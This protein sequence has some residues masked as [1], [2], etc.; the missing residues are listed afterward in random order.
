MAPIIALAPCGFAVSFYLPH[1]L[2]IMY[3]VNEVKVN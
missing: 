3:T 1:H 2:F